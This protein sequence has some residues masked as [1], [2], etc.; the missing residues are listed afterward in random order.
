MHT[1]FGA[2]LPFCA[3]GLL[4]VPAACSAG[5]PQT[6]RKQ[7]LSHIAYLMDRSD[8]IE[9]GDGAACAAVRGG[10][11]AALTE[12]DPFGK[13]QAL[14]GVSATV[15]QNERVTVQLWGT[16]D[17]SLRGSTKL[18]GE[19]TLEP[20]SGGM[21]DFVRIVKMREIRAAK[22]ASELEAKCRADA[23]PQKL[24][25]IYSAVVEL[26]GS[27][28]NS[29]AANR[30]CLLIIQSDLVETEEPGL[31]RAVAGI[32]KGQL[33]V[34][35]ATGLPAPIDLGGTISVF[36]C[37]YGASTDVTNATQRQEIL[38]LW[39]DKVFSGAK[40]FVQQASCPTPPSAA[41]APSR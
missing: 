21:E 41:A 17:A 34:E 32:R 20:P 35:K 4:V 30:E 11:L 36:V 31:A 22:V 28:R 39:K 18:L 9:R 23:K 12:L 14:E 38:R 27:L 8:S 26:V 3:V 16:A 15:Y 25:P 1:R 10:V 13:G 37:G 6:A 29:C 40:R 5:A 19:G 2:I 24:S 33:K 7:P